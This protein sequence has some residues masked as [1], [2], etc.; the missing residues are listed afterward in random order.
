TPFTSSSGTP[1]STSSVPSPSRSKPLLTLWPNIEAPWSPSRW[2]SSVWARAPAAASA[3][4][5][6]A[7]TGT[8]R[9]KG[10]EDMGHSRIRRS[11]GADG[12]KRRPVHR[13]R[14]RA[15]ALPAVR[16]ELLQFVAIDAAPEG[17]HRRVHALVG[18]HH[19]SHRERH[20]DV[21]D[22]DLDVVVFAVLIEE[23]PA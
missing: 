19:R 17:I 3:K 7:L 22:P 9:C 10:W 12:T 15:A 6:A 8:R 13:I 2:K 14:R 4:R 5:A 20:L 1:T 11:R 23:Q 21:A 16:E 18:L